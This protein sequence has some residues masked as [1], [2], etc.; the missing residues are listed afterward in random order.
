MSFPVD[1]TSIPSLVIENL[2][3]E[4]KKDEGSRKTVMRI[5]VFVFVFVLCF[6]LL[7]VI[8]IY[9][10]ITT[11]VSNPRYSNYYR[12]WGARC[13]S[14]VKAFAHGA[15]GRRIDPSWGGPIELFF[16][17]ASAPRLV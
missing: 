4:M 8:Y 16:V 14:V 17:P 7:F 5:F 1:I 10:S 11:L 2:I 9:Q 12:L 15:M 6:V 13:S 3:L